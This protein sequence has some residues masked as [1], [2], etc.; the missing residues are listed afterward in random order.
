MYP[1]DINPLNPIE[2]EILILNVKIVEALKILGFWC[3]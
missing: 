1:C 2:F 3:H